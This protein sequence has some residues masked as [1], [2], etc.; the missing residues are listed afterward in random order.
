VKGTLRE[1]SFTGNSES[2]IKHV[3]EGFEMEHPSL[4]S[5][6]E[7][8][9]KNGHNEHIRYTRSNNAQV[10]C[11]VYILSNGHEYGPVKSWS[12]P[13]PSQ[14]ECRMNAF[15]Y[16]NSMVMQL[17]METANNLGA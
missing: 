7:G 11:A 15:N 8:N 14:E 13:N 17:Y 5:P 2:F 10:A 3:K 4:Y 6:C 9:F 16:C 12:W 1:G